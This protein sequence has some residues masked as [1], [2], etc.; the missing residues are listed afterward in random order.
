MQKLSTTTTVIMYQKSYL[1]L[2]HT[3]QAYI[4]D[5]IVRRKLNLMALREI[6]VGV[7]ACGSEK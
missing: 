4:S 7:K 3:Q 2:A 1:I 6:N 5:K